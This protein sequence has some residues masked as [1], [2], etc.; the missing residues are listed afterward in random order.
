MIA[1]IPGKCELID[2][3]VTTSSGLVGVGGRAASIAAG[4]HPSNRPRLTTAARKAADACLSSSCGQCLKH[5]QPL[6]GT[7]FVRGW[8][9]DRLAQA[10]EIRQQKNHRDECQNNLCHRYE[11]CGHSLWCHVT[12]SEERKVQRAEIDEFKYDFEPRRSFQQKTEAGRVDRVET[13]IIQAEGKDDLHH[14]DQHQQHESMV[15]HVAA[16][17]LS[18]LTNVFRTKKCGLHQTD[19][20]DG[21]NADF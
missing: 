7:R 11:F 15:P 5:V 4:G 14:V 10:D 9:S 1:G 2:I 17:R 16:A 20:N 12:V 21:C 8:F 6:L 3:R 13:V 18:K 19:Q